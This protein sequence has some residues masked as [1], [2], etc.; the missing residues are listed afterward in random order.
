M[1]VAL[2]LLVWAGTHPAPSVMD[3]A[4]VVADARAEADVR[5]GAVAGVPAAA[6]TVASSAADVQNDV[7]VPAR[8][9]TA[10]RPEIVPASMV[11]T[12]DPPLQQATVCAAH[13]ELLMEKLSARAELPDA[14]FMIVQEYWQGRLPDPEG[15]NAIP[16]DAFSGIKQSLYDAA[17]TRPQTYLQGLQ[18]CVVSAVRGG[19][20][21]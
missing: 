21:D 17:D 10:A 3:P 9:A 15:Q 14:N 16:N 13:M 18:E 2:I 4:P 5:E 1:F 19:A 20:L 7:A 12:I 11:R 8:L 6:T